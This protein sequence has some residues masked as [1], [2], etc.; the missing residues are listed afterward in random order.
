MIDLEMATE[1]KN[2]SFANDVVQLVMQLVELCTDYY[3]NVYP[4]FDL[5]SSR[6]FHL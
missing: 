4:T 2:R 3:S 1:I 5:S 6:T